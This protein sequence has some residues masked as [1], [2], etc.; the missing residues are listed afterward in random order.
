VATDRLTRRYGGR[1]RLPSGLTGAVT[2]TVAFRPAAPADAHAIADLFVAAGRTGWAGFLTP[3]QLAQIEGQPHKWLERIGGHQ[4]N[5][6]L[7]L[8]TDGDGLAGFIWVHESGDLDLTEP[9]GEVGTFY[10]H[11]RVWGAGIGRLLME[12]G[13]DR[14]ATVGYTECVLWT[15]ARNE[16]P[17]RIYQQMGWTLDGVTRTRDYQGVPITEVR[18]RYHL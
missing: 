7:I 17:R 12:R 5:P 1:G 2:V 8:A 15:E 14:L 3:D 9:T 6:D 13:L 16:R 11:P 18:H 4:A 10:T